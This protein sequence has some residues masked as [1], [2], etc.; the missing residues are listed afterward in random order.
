M[1][2]RMANAIG[3]PGRLG[4]R[5]PKIYALLVGL[6]LALLWAGIGVSLWREYQ[7]EQHAAVEDTRNLVRAF[8]EN[9]VRTVEAVDQTLLVVRDAYARD[10]S[11]FRLSTWA[12]NAPFLNELALQITLIGP[13][14]IVLQSN[15]GP[16]TSRVDLSDR[17]HI[18]V[19]ATSKD[20]RLYISVPVLGRV[21]HKWSIQFTRKIIGPNGAYAGVVVVSLDPTTCP[22][23]TNPSRSAMATW[24]W[25]GSTAPFW[26]A[27]RRSRGRSDRRCRPRWSPRSSRTADTAPTNT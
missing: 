3:R 18:R 5:T 2:A 19:Q 9:L 1:T 17:E 27:R 7:L 13:D 16:V 8:S 15:L 12:T 11:G 14:G 25:P 22:S 26:R 6:T 21:S 20:D 10:P 4:L 24:S 23:F